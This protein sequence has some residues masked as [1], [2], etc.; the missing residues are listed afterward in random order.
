MKIGFVL[1]DYFPFGGLQEDCLATALSL[2]RRGHEI[3][4]FTRSW[5]SEQPS[6]IKAHILGKSGWTNISRNK[7]FFRSLKAELPQ[8]DLDG[9]VAFSR[10]PNCDIYFAADPCYVERV[11]DKSFWYRLGPRYRHYAALEKRVFETLN[12]PHTLVL[13]NREIDAFHRHYGTAR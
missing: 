9:V 5:K 4:I 10:I 6:T 7:H 1:N 3:H 12:P 2:A 11:K 13:T 8:H